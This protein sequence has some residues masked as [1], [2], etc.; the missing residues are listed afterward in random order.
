MPAVIVEPGAAT[1]C[2]DYISTVQLDAY[3]GCVD[4]ADLTDRT[5]DSADL[6]VD[7]T[8]D[9]FTGTVRFVR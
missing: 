4:F 9:V 3:R 2:W 8:T 1:G 7:I 5:D 6:E